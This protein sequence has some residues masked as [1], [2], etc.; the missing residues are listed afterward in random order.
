MNILHAPE[1]VWQSQKVL[2]NKIKCAV[3]N[4]ANYIS[5]NRATFLF[6]RNGGWFFKNF[7]FIKKYKTLNIESRRRKRGGYH[8]SLKY[9]KGS[10]TILAKKKVFKCSY[11][12]FIQNKMFVFIRKQTCLSTWTYCSSDSFLFGTSLLFIFFNAVSTILRKLVCH[13]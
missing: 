12:W 8:K 6:H 11:K 3:T 9:R 2:F 4:T 7:N 1:K 10:L 5:K 13:A